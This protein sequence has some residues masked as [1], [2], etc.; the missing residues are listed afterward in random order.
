MSYATR[1]LHRDFTLLGDSRSV[2]AQATGVAPARGTA[3]VH[4]ATLHA[5]A[6]ARL[7]IRWIKRQQNLAG[8]ALAALHPR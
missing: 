6:P 3:A 1:D 7:H 4:L 2:I 5:L 8:I